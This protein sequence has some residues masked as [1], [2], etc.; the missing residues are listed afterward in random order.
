MRTTEKI[1]SVSMRVTLTS[2]Y[3]FRCFPL[4]SSLR[5]RVILKRKYAARGE[6]VR[7]RD[8]TTC[9]LKTDSLRKTA[10]VCCIVAEEGSNVQVSS[11]GL[12][13]TLH[14]QKSYGVVC[15]RA[16]IS[17]T[18][19]TSVCDELISTKFVSR[20]SK[21]IF[22]ELICHTDFNLT[23]KRCAPFFPSLSFLIR[24]LKLSTSPKISLI[25]KF[26]E[27]MHFS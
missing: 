22:I 18:D 8:V 1:P 17:A 15:L 3:P 21:N 16:P 6:R 19:V 20:L 5:S 10:P 14:R 2:T 13:E 23:Y 12:C 7:F 26:S 4:Y 27:K 24:F 25:L 9:F 11:V